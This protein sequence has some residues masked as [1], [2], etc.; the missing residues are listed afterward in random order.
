VLLVALNASRMVLTQI[1]PE[2][3]LAGK[4]DDA[5]LEGKIS[6]V[7]TKVDQALEEI[8]VVLH[9]ELYSFAYKGQPP[10]KLSGMDYDAWPLPGFVRDHLQD[11][12]SQSRW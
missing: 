7:Q 4:S 8:E 6:E 11:G 12:Q 1:L 10:G 3:W 5:K 2:R 9:P